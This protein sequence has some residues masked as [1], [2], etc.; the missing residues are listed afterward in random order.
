M[1]LMPT[2]KCCAHLHLVK[3]EVK[4]SK[5]HLRESSGYEQ[6]RKCSRGCGRKE[7][8]GRL[9]MLAREA[10][11]LPSDLVAAWGCRVKCQEANA[12]CWM[13]GQCG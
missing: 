5:W 11:C 12:K 6:G 4:V 3:G 2:D 10:A 13:L 8:R 9:G 7:E 1:C